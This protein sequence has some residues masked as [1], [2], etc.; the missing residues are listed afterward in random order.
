MII[1]LQKEE[2]NMLIFDPFAC[3]SELV[4]NRGGHKK[5][6]TE[7]RTELTGTETEFTETELTETNFGA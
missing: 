2:A 3:N 5:P 4:S 7:H 1:T 6:E